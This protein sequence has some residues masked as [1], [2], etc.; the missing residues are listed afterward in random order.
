MGIISTRGVSIDKNILNNQ[1]Y[2]VSKKLEKLE[3]EIYSYSNERFNNV[4]GV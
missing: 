1:A 3:E 4:L 2:E